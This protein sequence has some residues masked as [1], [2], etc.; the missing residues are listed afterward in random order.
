MARR[1]RNR[2]CAGI[3]RGAC[4]VG[5]AAWADGILV[6]KVE[7]ESTRVLMANS[8]A[9]KPEKLRMPR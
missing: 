3:G 8:D 6:S 5:G 4:L 1:T 7:D 9:G 2:S